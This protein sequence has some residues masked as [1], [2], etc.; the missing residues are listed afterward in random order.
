MLTRRP[1]LSSIIFGLAA[2]AVTGWAAESEAHAAGCEVTDT[3][4]DAS[5]SGTLRWCVNKA[6]SGAYSKI[7]IDNADTYP[8]DVPLAISGSMLID[9]GMSTIVPA[10]G[11]VGDSLLEIATSCSGPCPLQN[12]V[13]RSVTL[14]GDGVAGPRGIDLDSGVVLEMEQ[15]VVAGFA[16]T[17]NGAGLRVT[18]ATVLITSTNFLGNAADGDGGGIYVDPSSTTAEL[19]LDDSLFDENRAFDGGGIH[20]G[21]A[22]TVLNALYTEFSENR[23][24]G[25]GGGVSGGGLFERCILAYNETSGFGGAI[26]SRDHSLTVLESFFQRN[27]AE[28]GG[29]ID[30]GGIGVADIRRSAFHHNQATGELGGGGVHQSGAHLTLVNSTLAHNEAQGG[31]TGAAGVSIDSGQS[32]LDNL[33]FY[34]NNGSGAGAAEGLYVAGPAIVDLRNSLFTQTGLNCEI[35]GTVMASTSYANDFSCGPGVIPV[36]GALTASCGGSD[37]EYHCEPS[38][39]LQGLGVC[40]TQVDQ[41]GTPRPTACFPGSIELP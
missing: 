41:I 22:T 36:P 30:V 17:D 15:S 8:L 5:V 3:Q 11:F 7:I 40:A 35:A 29:A 9:G 24:K 26:D 39:G 34:F 4:D 2:V 32:T 21:N 27:I 19:H 18:D 31:G 28:T 25:S 37:F 33:T 12:V 6:L 14:D 10:S 13:L 38:P 23:A 20:V 1:R 16:T